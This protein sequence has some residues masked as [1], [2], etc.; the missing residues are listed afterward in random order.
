MVSR[1]PSSC[2]CSLP[3]ESVSEA[4]CA[5]LK[6]S[7][8]TPK[9][10]WNILVRVANSAPS[11]TRLQFASALWTMATVLGC[12]PPKTDCSLAACTNAWNS[13]GPRLPSA[14]LSAP[15]ANCRTMETSTQKRRWRPS[16]TGASS[17]LSARP[18]RSLSIAL[19][20]CAIF[21]G[22]SMEGLWPWHDTNKCLKAGLS[23]LPAGLR[24]RSALYFSTGR[25]KRRCSLDATASSSAPS[26]TPLL[27]L[28]FFLKRC[29]MCGGRKDSQAARSKCLNS[30]GSSWESWFA[31]A[32]VKSCW[33]I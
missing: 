5:C 8:A 23:I 1:C 29:A 24:A 20:K 4:F 12:T 32:S 14:F 26:R 6:R 17:A 25:W 31:S 22:N 19:K 27:S 15:V 33:Y 2:G 21:G 16:V 7:L 11:M 3:S 13:P 18:L 28:S 9:R 30:A 10:L